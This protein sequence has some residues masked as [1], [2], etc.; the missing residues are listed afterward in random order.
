[1]K[2]ILLILV[3]LFAFSCDSNKNLPDPVDANLTPSGLEEREEEDINL[4]DP[5]DENLTPAQEE[6]RA[7][8]EKSIY[9]E[10]EEY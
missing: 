1:M 8:E 4:S 7:N 3:S 6:E 9:S 5:V 10:E 2:T